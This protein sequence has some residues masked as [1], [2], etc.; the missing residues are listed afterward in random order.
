MQKIL[1]LCLIIFDAGCI[2]FK[3]KDKY[4]STIELCNLAPKTC[5]CSLYL[6]HYIVSRA[7]GSTDIDSEYFTDSNSFRIYTGSY[8][9]GNERLEYTCKGDTVCF[10][11]ITNKDLGQNWDTFRIIEKKIY[12]IKDLKKQGKFE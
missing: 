7:F 10:Q 2:N 9:E 11:K 4:K 8:D 5:S 3:S 12:V 1:L 6:E